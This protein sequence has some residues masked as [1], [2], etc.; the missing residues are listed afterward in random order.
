MLDFAQHVSLDNDTIARPISGHVSAA[1]K[2]RKRPPALSTKGAKMVYDLEAVHGYRVQD[3]QE[4]LYIKWVGYP[5]SDNTW[6]PLNQVEE[7]QPETVA[8]YMQQH[9]LASPR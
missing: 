1:R 8:E 9:G 2:I 4:Q 6:E 5:A 7:D 3:G